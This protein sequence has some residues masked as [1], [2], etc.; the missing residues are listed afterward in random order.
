M[1]EV[2]QR[3]QPGLEQ[4]LQA[5]FQAVFHLNGAP[6]QDDWGPGTLDGWDSM[7]HL[8]LLASL[9]Q[10]FKVQFQMDDVIAIDSVKAIKELLV[11]KGL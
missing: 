11:R 3:A 6:L 8:T 7:G 4:R 1:D 2:D 9:E 10:E 5:V